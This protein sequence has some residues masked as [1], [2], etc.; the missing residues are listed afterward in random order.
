[1]ERFRG[2]VGPRRW[3][4]RPKIQQVFAAV[5][6]VED[7]I[8]RD[9]LALGREFDDGTLTWDDL[10]AVIFAA[11]PGSAVFHAVEKG[12]TTTDYLLAHVIDGVRVNNWQ[13]TEGARKRPPRNVPDP[14]PRPA[15]ETK[16]VRRDVGDTAAIGDS[17]AT[18]ITVEDYAA[19]RAEREQRWRDKQQ[20]RKGGG[21]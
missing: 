14:F 17:I 2:A 13:R 16:K 15:D 20:K 8:R 19:R 11:P 5:R 10:Y 18:V 9:L 12:W 7:A 3:A 6:Q 21:S 4:D 1:M